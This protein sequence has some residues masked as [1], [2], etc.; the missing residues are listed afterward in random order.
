MLAFCTGQRSPGEIPPA[1]RAVPTGLPACYALY[2]G[3]FDRRVDGTFHNASPVV[4]LDTAA[5]FHVLEDE[6]FRGFR[7]LKRLDTAGREL[8]LQYGS[9]AWWADSLS[10]SLH[11]SFSDGYS[12][13]HVVLRMGQRPDS[14]M[15]GR[16]EEQWD[17]QPPGVTPRGRAQARRVTCVR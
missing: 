10:D 15:E 9:Q 5:S 1:R 12:G 2:H 8:A 13:T 3:D 11:L 17:V 14:V 16:I 4:R 7:A 6:W